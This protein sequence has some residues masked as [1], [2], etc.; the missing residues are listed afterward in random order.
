MQT[1]LTENTILTYLEIAVRRLV[2]QFNP[3]QVFLFGS[4]AWGEPDAD[5]A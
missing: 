2:E 3:E 5:N 1:T 4:Y